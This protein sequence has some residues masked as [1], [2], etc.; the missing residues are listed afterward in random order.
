[1]IGQ[2]EPGRRPERGAGI[3]KMQLGPAE[4]A[5]RRALCSDLLSRGQTG[6]VRTDHRATLTVFMLV[7]GL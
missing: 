4:L 5:R 1:M 6:R 2:L 7:W 3:N